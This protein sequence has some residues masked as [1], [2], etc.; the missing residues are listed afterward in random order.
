[1]SVIATRLPNLPAQA[2]PDECVNDEMNVTR[3]EV[4]RRFRAVARAGGFLPKGDLEWDD[5]VAIRN[6]LLTCGTLTL[7]PAPEWADAQLALVVAND[8]RRLGI[9]VYVS[10]MVSAFPGIWLGRSISAL[11]GDEASIVR[12]VLQV[13]VVALLTFALISAGIRLG[14]RRISA[15]WKGPVR[16]TLQSGE[17]GIE[18]ARD[19]ALMV[20]PGR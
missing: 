1:M 8:P 2:L 14:G 17:C 18:L 3:A 15:A 5:P 7:T 9:A 6:E 20:D 12:P 19:S 11:V 13:G 16:R 4:W 10:L